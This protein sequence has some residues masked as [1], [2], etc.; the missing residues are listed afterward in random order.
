MLTKLL[1]LEPT[2]IKEI[3]ATLGET[4]AKCQAE[5]QHKLT[6]L[7]TNPSIAGSIKE[8]MATIE[9]LNRAAREMEKLEATATK[10]MRG[11]ARKLQKP[12]Q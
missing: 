3:R 5:A 11:M 1:S 10:I 8:H 9:I 6:S 4:I 12:A 2:N 7:Q